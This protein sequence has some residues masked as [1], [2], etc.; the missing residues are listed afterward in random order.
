MRIIGD[1]G[2]SD[3]VNKAIVIHDSWDDCGLRALWSLGTTE[4]Q[5]ASAENGNA[6][7]R[8]ACGT[9]LIS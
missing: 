8:L 9:I 4:Q 2:L 1:Y 5:I 7:S 3:L 6:G